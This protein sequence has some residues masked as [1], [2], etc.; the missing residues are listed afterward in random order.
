MSGAPRDHPLRGVLHRL[1]ERERGGAPAPAVREPPQVHAR[2]PPRMLVVADAGAGEAALGW[3]A[4][5]AGLLGRSPAVV[6]LFSGWP[7]DRP[8]IPANGVRRAVVACEPNRLDREPLGNVV[9]MLD[10]LRRHESRADLLLLR[11]PLRHRH[12]ILRA[13]LLAG[14]L[15]VALDATEKA[16]PAALSLARDALASVADLRLWAFSPSPSALGRFL[17][18]AGESGSPALALDPREIDLAAALEALPGAPD[19]GFLTAVVAP[20]PASLPA[21]LLAIES[22]GA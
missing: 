7:A 17:E 1:I 16:V 9:A 20:A 12:P 6:E 5:W 18:T 3:V 15:V 4:E 22:D 2:R 11:I 14:A 8:S 19:G 13:T 21:D 10:A